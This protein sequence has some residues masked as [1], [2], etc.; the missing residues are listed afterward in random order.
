MQRS[1]ASELC[2]LC[3]VSGTT[4]AGNCVAPGS[5]S[6][7]HILSQRSMGSS[8]G[9]APGAEGSGGMVGANGAVMGRRSIELLRQ[10]GG[11]V[12]GDAG[13]G[14]IRHESVATVDAQAAAD[15]VYQSV[16]CMHACVHSALETSTLSVLG[17]SR[18]IS[19][20]FS[21]PPN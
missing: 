5:S 17:V 10:H 18:C 20:Q 11:H 3:A 13:D 21:A 2:P 15:L 7:R 4:H 8:R 14:D 12:Q 16:C 1:T 6:L 9:T 19:E